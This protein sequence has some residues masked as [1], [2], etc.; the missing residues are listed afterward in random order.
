MGRDVRLVHDLESNIGK[1][2]PTEKIVA[3]LTNNIDKC[4]FSRVGKMPA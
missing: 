4:S 3:H 1:A 2:C